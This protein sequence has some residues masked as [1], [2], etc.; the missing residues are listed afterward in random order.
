MVFE[1]LRKRIDNYKHPFVPNATEFMPIDID[2][3][4]S[5]LSLVEKGT[6]RGKSEL[7]RTDSSGYDEIE[8]S[9]INSIIGARATAKSDYDLTQSAYNER[10]KGL[11]LSAR[12]SDIRIE[13]AKAVSDFDT[14]HHSGADELYRLR[15]NVLDSREELE[16]FKKDRGIRRNARYP[17]S[18]AYHYG[19]IIFLF[20][21]EGLL[22][23]SVFG[24]GHDAGLLGGILFAMGIAFVNVFVL[25]LAG[26]LCFKF[27]CQPSA[28]WKALGVICIPVYFTLVFALC[29]LGAHIRSAMN[30]GVDDFNVR[31][32]ETLRETPFAI[33]DVMSLIFIIMTMA[34][35]VFAA[36]DFFKMNDPIFS[37]GHLDK[38]LKM[39]EDDYR[40]TKDDLAYELQD[41]REDRVGFMKDQLDELRQHLSTHHSIVENRAQQYSRFNDYV[42]YLESTANTLLSRYRDA[43]RAARKTDE[44][45]HFGEAWKMPVMELVKYGDPNEDIS[46]VRKK[47]EETSEI[48]EE[49]IKQIEGHYVDHVHR[50]NRIDELTREELKSAQATTQA[51]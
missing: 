42:T 33:G 15:L 38:K 7:P 16:E 44:P 50:Y 11:N 17:E 10:L 49:Y 1:R 5:D 9:I 19:F 34:F 8:N 26:S 4:A 36:I 41:I 28:A 37:F 51:A 18:L 32:F 27:I 22:N 12:S 13:A 31:A 30:A 43:N 48:L 45:K 46:D 40:S 2:K 35:S 29:L 20:A 6:E 23:G 47:V 3:V 25:G 24:Q 39:A 14:S 21:F